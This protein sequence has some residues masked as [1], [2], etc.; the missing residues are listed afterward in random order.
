[1]GRYTD[2][3][4]LYSLLAPRKL[5][6]LGGY[7]DVLSD[8]VLEVYETAKAAYSLYGAQHDLKYF[9]DP[10]GGHTY[11]KPMR[12]ALYR[13]F[14]KWLKNVDD[15]SQAIEMFDPEDSLI[16]KESGLLKVFSDARP[17]KDVHQLLID[18]AARL[19]AGYTRPSTPDEVSRYQANLRAQ[20][21]ALMGDMEPARSPPVAADDRMTSPG[22][23]RRVTLKTERDLPVPV[24]IY[25]PAK[26]ETHTA[27]IVLV[28][29]DQNGP[30][31]RQIRTLASLG[32]VVAVPQVRGSG[33]TLATNMDSVALYSMA[34]GKHLFATRIYDLQCVINYLSDQQ[35]YRKLGFVVWGDGTREGVMALYLAAIDPRV[36]GAISSHSIVDYQRFITSDSLPEFDYYLPGILKH[37]D[38]AEII[39]AIAPRRVIVHAPKDAENRPV[40]IEAAKSVYR[41]AQSVYK[42][43]GHETGFSIVSDAEFMKSLVGN[44]WAQ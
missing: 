26:L 43:L 41:S 37:A 31:L 3:P 6:L 5:L 7:Y 14:N 9:L 19:K 36:R 44:S 20:L 15:P 28:S 38:V 34:L 1:M 12:L 25:H 30:Q 32:F 10:D 40:S 4:A 23:I 27:V 11:S 24:S 18:H 42:I 29:L 16:S 13:W 21:V 17:G 22:S 39:S 2:Y 8:R 35:Q 33:P